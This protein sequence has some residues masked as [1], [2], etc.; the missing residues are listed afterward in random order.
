[1]LVYLRLHDRLAILDQGES[2]FLVELELEVDLV[3]E[4]ASKVEL[5]L[6]LL[7]VEEA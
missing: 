3:T 5:N 1:V 2:L 6:A 4:V 7:L